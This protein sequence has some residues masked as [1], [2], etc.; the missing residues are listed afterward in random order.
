VSAV[1]RKGV[2]YRCS[3]IYTQEVLKDLKIRTVV[4]LRG[5]AEKGGKKKPQL[6]RTASGNHLAPAAA[7]DVRGTPAPLLPAEARDALAAAEANSKL[8]PE[9]SQVGKGKSRGTSGERQGK[10]RR[11]AGDRYSSMG[12]GVE[13]DAPDTMDVIQTLLLVVV[14]HSSSLFV[15]STALTC[16]SRCVVCPVLH[17]RQAAQAAGVGLATM[18]GEDF[19]AVRGVRGMDSLS[20]ADEAGSDTSAAS[21]APIPTPT[22]TTSP[23][24][25]SSGQ[26]EA[27]SA[28]AMAAAAMEEAM[29]QVENFNLIPNKEF[30]LTMLRMPR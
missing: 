19:V 4:D 10:R 16:L 15:P 14:G 12:M 17:L 29:A 30:G 13:W 24:T 28:S 18:S 11:T 8:T 9:Q 25:S 2:L 3:Q 1:L 22:P 21:S 23:T 27:S 20:S 6:E 5:R 7:T 26:K